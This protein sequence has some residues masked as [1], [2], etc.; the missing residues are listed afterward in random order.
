MLKNQIKIGDIVE[1]LDWSYAVDAFN[2]SVPTSSKMKDSNFKV[3]SFGKK[4]PTDTDVMDDLGLKTP[5]N[6]VILKDVQTGQIVFSQKRF[7]NLVK[8]QSGGDMLDN[9]LIQYIKRGS[10]GNVGV[11]VA[12]PV[13]SNVYFGWSKVHTKYD[14]FNK[15]FS[16][17]V[18]V[19]R[20]LREIDLTEVPYSITKEFVRFINRSRSYYKDKKF[21]QITDLE[22]KFM[23]FDVKF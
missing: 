17:D 14:V 22:R 2:N 19:G 9:M 8:K 15:E 4:L 7:L 6:D 23:S 1:I 16:K 12:I 13:G 18:A 5:L 3:I 20:A 11:M 21:P 10:K